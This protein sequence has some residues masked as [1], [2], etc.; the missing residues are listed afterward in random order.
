MG[1]LKTPPEDGGRYP[2]GHPPSRPYTVLEHRLVVN[3]LCLC[4]GSADWF[5][6]CRALCAALGRKPSFEANVKPTVRK[7]SVACENVL[8]CE[9][10]KVLRG[11]GGREIIPPPD[12]GSRDGRPVTWG[13]QKIIGRWR[14]LGRP[15]SPQELAWFLGRWDVSEICGYDSPAD[16]GW[17]SHVREAA[18][19]TVLRQVAGGPVPLPECL[20]PVKSL[21]PER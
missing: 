14:R 9:L 8:C 18:L 5:V 1:L 6:A 15:C 4:R 20:S 12:R 21:F 13:E 2:N 3:T 17:S 16:N 10:W 7:Y 11:Y 19:E